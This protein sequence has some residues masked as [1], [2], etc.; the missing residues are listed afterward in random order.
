MYVTVTVSD[1]TVASNAHSRF[2]RFDL[3]LLERSRVVRLPVVSWWALVKNCSQPACFFLGLTERD[4]WDRYKLT[5]C[6]ELE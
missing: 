1:T 4:A 5:Q 3:F 2:Y 6:V